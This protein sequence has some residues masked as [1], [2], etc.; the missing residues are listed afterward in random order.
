[1][2]PRSKDTGLPRSQEVYVKLAHPLLMGFY[3][4]F[5][6]SYNQIDCFWQR[7]LR[8]NTILGKIARQKLTRLWGLWF[9][10]RNCYQGL[11]VSIG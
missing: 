9:A 1:I 11:S 4:S 5:A 6:N 2:P 3:I 7:L 8:I 10:Y